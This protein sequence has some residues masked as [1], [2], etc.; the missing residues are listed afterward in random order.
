MRASDRPSLIQLERRVSRTFNL[1]SLSLLQTSARLS[2]TFPPVDALNTDI[3]NC[4]ARLGLS[5]L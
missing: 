2:R 5:R 4:G 3:P 1:F